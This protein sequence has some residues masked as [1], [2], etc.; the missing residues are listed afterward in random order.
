MCMFDLDDWL[1]NFESCVYADDLINKIDLLNHQIS[2]KVDVVKI[3]K[4]IYYA[5]KYHANQMRQSGEPYYSHPLIVAGM[6]ADYCFKTD[7]LVTAILHDTIE[8][9]KLTKSMIN[10]I[11]DVHIANNVDDL[12]RVKSYGKITAAEM[13]KLL[14]TEKKYDLLLIKY[15]DRL[16]NLQTIQAKSPTKIQQTIQETLKQFISLSL[17][18]EKNNMPDLMTKKHMDMVDLCLKQL[19]KKFS[20]SKTT[21]TTLINDFSEWAESFLKLKFS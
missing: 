4:A 13:I 6:V 3:K 2:S 15:F 10:D 12:T 20:N 11:F 5:K 9:T 17:Y 16:H 18:F 1:N 14:W 7:I 21:N 19:P 8:D